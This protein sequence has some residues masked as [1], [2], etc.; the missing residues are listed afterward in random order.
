MKIT[1][2]S[3]LSRL[4]KL[5]NAIY[6]GKVRGVKEPSLGIEAWTLVGICFWVTSLKLGENCER[7]CKV[8]CFGEATTQSEISAMLAEISD[9]FKYDF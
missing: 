6:N 2:K 7:E 8:K 3:A 1:T 9:F 5:Q 4:R